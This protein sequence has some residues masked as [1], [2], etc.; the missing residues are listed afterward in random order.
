[1]LEQ[2]SVEE[3]TAVLQRAMLSTD[4]AEIEDALY[5][6]LRWVVARVSWLQLAGATDSSEIP[7]FP[8]A[9]VAELGTI[10][11][12]RRQPSLDS[13]IGTASRLIDVIPA[14]MVV[15]VVLAQRLMQG[16]EDLLVETEY[17]LDPL[18]VPSHLRQI[19]LPTLRLH[20][21]HLVRSLTKAG[22]NNPILKQWLESAHCDPLPE[23]RRA[24]DVPF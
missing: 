14:Q 8:D 4:H 11:A 22:F 1:M 9:L 13:A 23:V 20:A 24:A 12:M 15:K 21:T 2:L 19:D 6:L 5:A 10:V 3:T 16:L 18:D 17:R 7:S